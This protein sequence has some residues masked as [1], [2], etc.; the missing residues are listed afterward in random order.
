VERLSRVEDFIPG[1]L[2]QWA[3]VPNGFGQS[4]LEKGIRPLGKIVD[5]CDFPNMASEIGIEVID[6]PNWVISPEFALS[7]GREFF[8]VNPDQ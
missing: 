6:A 1:Q 2:V 3:W 7:K 4:A 8:K 5:K